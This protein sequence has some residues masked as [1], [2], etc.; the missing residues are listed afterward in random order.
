MLMQYRKGGNLYAKKTKAIYCN[1]RWPPAG[2]LGICLQDQRPSGLAI[3]YLKVGTLYSFLG[4]CYRCDTFA[5]NLT[6]YKNPNTWAQSTH[7]QIL[8]FP[9][10][11]RRSNP[12]RRIFLSRPFRLN[13]SAM[14]VLLLFQP[15]CFNSF[16]MSSFSKLATFNFKESSPPV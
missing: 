16:R 6:Q 4:I 7:F 12:Y 5:W 11:T 13:P 9:C 15:F 3:I 2:L 14:A 8:R 1:G 10:L